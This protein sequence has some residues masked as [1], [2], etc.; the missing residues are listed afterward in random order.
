M[1]QFSPDYGIKDMAK[2]TSKTATLKRNNSTKPRRKRNSKHTK[3]TVQASLE[4]SKEDEDQPKDIAKLGR[5]NL[6]F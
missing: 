2:M 4:R 1:N 5:F 6:G 3:G